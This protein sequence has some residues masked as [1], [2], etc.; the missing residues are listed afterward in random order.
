[1]AS[2]NTNEELK[3]NLILQITDF[4]PVEGNASAKQKLVKLKLSDGVSQMPG[5]VT[6]SQVEQ[7]GNLLWAVIELRNYIRRQVAQAGQ[8]IMVREFKVV[9]GGMRSAI[10][11]PKGYHKGRELE[12]GDPEKEEVFERYDYRIQYKFAPV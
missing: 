1:M 8:M 6:Q 9:Y 12:Y 11:E 7:M 10:G 3:E 5:I 2:V 4:K